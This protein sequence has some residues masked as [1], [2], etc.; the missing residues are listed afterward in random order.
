MDVLLPRSVNGDR[1]RTG[2]GNYR[3][4]EEPYLEDRSRRA[5]ISS[6]VVSGEIAFRN[7]VSKNAT[8]SSVSRKVLFSSAMLVF[9]SS[10]WCQLKLS[11]K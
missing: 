7:I 6:W 8:S 11:G 1:I 9:I 2:Q 4:V 3:G 10:V 5:A